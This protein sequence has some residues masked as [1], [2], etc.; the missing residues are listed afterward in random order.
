MG[1]R[2][3]GD[4]WI[5][6]W[7]D[8]W[9]PGRLRNRDVVDFGDFVDLGDW[10]IVRSGIVRLLDCSGGRIVRLPDWQIVGMPDCR[11]RLEIVRSGIAGSLDCWIV[12]L[13]DC[14]I[15]RL[16]DCWNVR[17]SER[18]IARSADLLRC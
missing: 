5:A 12:R 8:C 15:G 13:S 14:Q 16:L 6:G 3:V 17:L 11:I 18:Q 10:E 2:A 1:N 7:L 4:C 9:I